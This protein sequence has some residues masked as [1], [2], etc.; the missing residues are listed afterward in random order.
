MSAT[1]ASVWTR[2]LERSVEAMASVTVETVTVLLVG[3]ETNVSSSVTSAHGKARGDA[4][5]QMAKSAATEGL[6]CVGSVTAMMWI[7]LET[8]EIFMET[9][10]SAMRG[11]VMLHTTGTPMTSAQVMVSATVAAAIA[12]KDGQGRSVSTLCPAPCLW[13][14]A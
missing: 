2:T 1:T 11:T 8:G 13:T 5:L 3:M 4:H 10:A 9:P 14:A 6:V 7:P 12:R